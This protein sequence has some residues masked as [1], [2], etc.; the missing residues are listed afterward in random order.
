M[1]SIEN[2]NVIISGGAGEIGK[3]IAAGFLGLGAK[4]LIIGRNA[5]KLKQATK[6]LSQVA[7][8][9]E[10]IKLDVTNIKNYKDLKKYIKT[11][12]YNQVDV[13][14]NAA[15]VYGPIGPLESNDTKEWLDTFAVNV[16]GTVFMTQMVIPLMKKR[17]SG[18]IINFSGGGDGPFPNFTAY[19][20]SKGAIVRFTESIASEL[21]EFNIS[22]NAIAPGAVNSQFLEKVLIAGPKK[23]GKNFYEKSLKQKKEGGVSP[24]RAT[25]LVLFLASKKGR[26]LSG[27]V[28]SAVYD[29]WSEFPS[30]IKTI[31][32]T[33]IYNV[34]RIKPKDRGYDW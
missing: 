18:C 26:K 29:N 19:S 16:F 30:H 8:S 6:E 21:K 7:G 1:N 22:V 33:D 25:D 5:S 28:L 23:S 17:E 31:S 2:R 11:I 24:R 10:S 27:K 20:S 13:L 34:R 4:V 9:I 14:I 15:G 32:S 3:T 12:F